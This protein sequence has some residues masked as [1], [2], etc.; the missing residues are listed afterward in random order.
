MVYLDQGAVVVSGSDDPSKAVWVGG[1][2]IYGTV[3]QVREIIK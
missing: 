2:Q 3:H 1:V